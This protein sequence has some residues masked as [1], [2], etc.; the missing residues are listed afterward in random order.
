[1]AGNMSATDGTFNSGFF[2]GN[3]TSSAIITGGTFRT[4]ASGTRIEMSSGS[5]AN[6]FNLYS[7]TTRSWIAGESDGLYFQGAGLGYNH[8]VLYGPTGSF[9]SKTAFMTQ[10]RITPSEDNLFTTAVLGD[11]RLRNIT[12]NTS[13]PNTASGA[14]G[15]SGGYGSLFLVYTD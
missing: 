13:T 7:G 12:T 6:Y 14:A 5:E 10:V 15:I 4:A 1:M 9:P 3:I 8:L 11:F 2:T